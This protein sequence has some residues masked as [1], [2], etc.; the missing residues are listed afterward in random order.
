MLVGIPS[1]RLPGLWILCAPLIDKAIQRTDCDFDI[2]D[3]YQKAL[4]KDCQVWAWIDGGKI[5]ACFV[6]TLL[7]HPKR[8]ICS[9][10]LI[11]GA[12]LSVWRNGV[13]E[14]LGKWAKEQGCEYLE[15]YARKGWLRVL[16]DWSTISTTIRR[17][18]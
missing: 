5:T 10:P 17:K 1:E 14:V 13:D 3:I 11:G 18:L 4:T 6:T 12:G 8:K 7:I 2:D 15:G 9:V 16:K